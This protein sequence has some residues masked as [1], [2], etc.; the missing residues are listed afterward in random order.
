[1]SFMRNGRVAW[2][3]LSAVVAA[4]VGMGSAL[5]AYPESDVAHYT[6]C[7]TTSGQIKSVALSDTSPV[8][9]CGPNETLI[10]LSGGDITKVAA[11][12]GLTGGGD[13]GALTLALDGNYALPQGCAVNK[14]AQ[15][16]GTGWQCADDQNTSYSNG[17]GLDLNAGTF[18]I[19]S[20]YQLPQG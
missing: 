16:N 15:W 9:A 18:S 11:G 6:G 1:M 17:T 8:S 14:I 10:H 12:A 3:A 5:A 20:A 19:D 4:L 13:N 2:L 7:L